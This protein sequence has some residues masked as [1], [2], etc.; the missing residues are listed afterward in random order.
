MA[1]AD[2]SKIA[3]SITLGTDHV[4]RGLS[5]T[6]GDPAIV[7]EVKW[8]HDAGPFIG[9]IASNYRSDIDDAS[10]VAIT[11]FFGVNKTVGGVNL[12]AGYL[13]RGRTDAR[14]R[15]YSEVTLSGG[16][17]LGPVSSRLGAFYSWDHYAGRDS[18]YLYLDSRTKLGAV[19]RIPLSL[20]THLGRFDTRGTASDYSDVRAGLSAK[21]PVMT[22][23]AQ[24]SYADADRQTSRLLGG[25]HGGTRLTAT[26]FFLF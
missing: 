5:Q 21:L 10:G 17:E 8:N 24:L 11:P 14:R 18:T 7:G 3:A 4:W 9:I 1:R 22:L 23:G 13:Y 6:G 20:T 16:V 15:D 25:R 2:D 12:D 19:G 26:A